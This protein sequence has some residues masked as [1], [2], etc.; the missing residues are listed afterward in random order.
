MSDPLG[1]EESDPGEDTGPAISNWQFVG[2]APSREDTVDLLDTLAPVYGVKTVDYADFVQALPQKLKVKK[3]HPEN[4]RL[5][6]EEYVEA[7]T[8]YVSVAGR[9]KMLNDAQAQ[10]G[11][12]VEFVPEPVT[13]TGIPGYLQNDDR[14]VYREYVRIVE[15]VVDDAGSRDVPLGSR[16]GTA[17]VPTKGGSNAAGSNP[18]EK[19]ETSARGRA[20]GAWGFGVL[21]GSGIASLEEMQNLAGNR[22]ALDAEP[23]GRGTR[24]RKPRA[25]LLSEALELMEQVRLARHQEPAEIRAKV[26]DYLATSLGVAGAYDAAEDVLSLDRL[27]DGQL[28]ILANQFRDTLTKIAGQEAPV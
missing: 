23:V 24:Q 4:P 22:A 9:I 10:A 13:P 19:V 14:L 25:E 8:L 11:W 5:V 1:G 6:V 21:P 28:T 2:R 3:P 7:Y 12:S 20:L 26:A 27:R 16:P 15:H 18:Y 17:W